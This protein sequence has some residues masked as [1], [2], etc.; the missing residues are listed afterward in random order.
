MTEPGIAR[1][2]DPRTFADQPQEMLWQSIDDSLAMP[3]G[4]I[5]EIQLAA[6]RKRFEEMREK[7]PPL[8]TLAAEN[9]I[10]GIAELNAAASLLFKHSVYKSYPVSL[11]EKSRFDRMT[12][13]L[14]NLTTQDL[15]DVRTDGLE[16]DR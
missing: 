5:A 9:G 1:P 14:G 15:S 2:V 11:I 6:V 10:A 8:A 16:F 7:L 4:D 12:Q 13:W 3:A